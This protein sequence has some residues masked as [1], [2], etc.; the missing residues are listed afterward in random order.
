MALYCRRLRHGINHNSRD[1]KVPDIMY[2]SYGT[3]A[4]VA[5]IFYHS[6]R[7]LELVS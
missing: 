2:N 1:D 7:I 6:N 3:D 4:Y 5:K